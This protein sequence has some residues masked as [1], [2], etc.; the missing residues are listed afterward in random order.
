MH[1]LYLMVVLATACAH[2]QPQPKFPH[3]PIRIV[4]S[5]TAGSQPDGLSRFIA[6]KM[7]ASWGVPV[8]IDNRPGGSG[9]LAASTVSKATPDGHTL[10]YALPN[11][12]IST[13]MQPSLPY[14]PVRDFTGVAHIGMSTNILVASPALGVK[15]VKDFI[16]LAHSQPGKLI[17][18]SSATGSA[19][20]LSGVR[21][22]IAA[23]LKVVHVAFK[24]GPDSMIE[25]LAGRAHYHLGTLGTT[26]PFIKE[27]KL[28]ALAVTSPQRTPVLPDVPA[29][30]ETY[31]EF[32][33]PETSHGLL[34]P[35]G[36]PRAIIQQI[37][38]ETVRIVDSPEM[39]ER[40]QLI[41]FVPTPAGADEYT[42]V[43]RE[44]IV[45]MARLVRDAGLKGR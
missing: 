7:S 20:H 26:L 36:T 27:G 35:A 1:L 41:G 34:V 30:G 4:V 45:A 6:Q 44:Q 29:L 19:A 31:A 12:V 40:M 24:G 25:V 37:S 10:M 3:K 15:S 11:F 22:N 9:L 2:A 8:V 39:R 23:A 42:R 32:K 18:S 33:R 5:T 13:A 38:A 16:A 21:F 14:D 28:T 17:F 43:V